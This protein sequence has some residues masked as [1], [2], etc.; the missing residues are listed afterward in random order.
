MSF[1]LFRHDLFS[2]VR[3]LLLLRQLY[4]SDRHAPLA[5]GLSG[6]LNPMLGRTDTG[7]VYETLDA[8]GSTL[9]L[10]I[11][12]S[13]GDRAGEHLVDVQRLYLTGKD[14]ID[15]DLKP[16]S[17]ARNLRRLELIH[18]SITDAG[19]GYLGGLAALEQLT[20]SNAD[21]TD[22]GFGRFLASESGGFCL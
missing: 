12:R 17:S 8:L 5:L 2:A 10:I 1:N 14:V 7:Y 13:L 20:I 9:D 21:I 15:Q 16:L 18:T 3:G 4:W 11:L 19:M 6:D 22:G